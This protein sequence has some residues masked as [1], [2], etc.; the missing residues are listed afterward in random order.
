MPLVENIADNSIDF[1]SENG[2]NS[3]EQ[4]CVGRNILQLA[5]PFSNFFTNYN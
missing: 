1:S 5:V 3:A 4:Y 2:D